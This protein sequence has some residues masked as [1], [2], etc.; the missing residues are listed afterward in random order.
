MPWSRMQRACALGHATRLEPDG[1]GTGPA[2]TVPAG[3]L[4]M[5]RRSWWAAIWSKNHW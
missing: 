2:Q 1:F 4:S 5:P 3:V